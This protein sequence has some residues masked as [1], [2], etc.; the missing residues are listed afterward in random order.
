MAYQIADQRLGH[1]SLTRGNVGDSPHR[2]ITRRRPDCVADEPVNGEP[3]CGANSLLTGNLTGNFHKIGLL[4]E[5][6]PI[7]TLQN[8]LVAGQFPT[9]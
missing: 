8:Q 6:L 9:T 5:N 2:E 3:V 4:S 1:P 7:I